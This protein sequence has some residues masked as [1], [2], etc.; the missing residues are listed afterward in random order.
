MLRF[1]L[2]GL[3]FCVSELMAQVEIFNANSK[4]HL[5]SFAKNYRL[6]PK[7]AD[8][9][10]E[11]NPT[12]PLDIL[13][14]N[15]T[16]NGLN[17]YILTSKNQNM[18]LG[19]SE[20]NGFQRITLQ[21]ISDK[22]EEKYIVQKYDASKTTEATKYIQTV[23]DSFL[24]NSGKALQNISVLSKNTTFKNIKMP[25]QTRAMMLEG[26][27]VYMFAFV[28]KDEL[29]DKNGIMLSSAAPSMPVNFER[30]SDFYSS[31]RFHPILKYFAP[32]EGVDLAAKHG[33]PVLCALEGY[34]SEL[35]YSPNIGNYVRIAHQNGF[36][37]VYGH[38]SKTRS[39]L[40]V[41]KSVQRKEIIGLVGQTGL[42][43]GPHLH[44]GVKKDGRYIDPAIFFKKQEYRTYDKEFFAFASTA[45]EKLIKNFNR[46]GDGIEN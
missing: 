16:A 5:Y 25:P 28:F 20:N 37:S 10:L 18:R 38:L 23:T 24:R 1:A 29:F 17:G 12:F 41:G 43:T 2:L 44:F 21:T 27:G 45:R 26:G 32:H 36:E 22:F 19:V 9:I 6:S 13:I 4:E 3:L 34:V 8:K 40:A 42:A 7:L 31:S 14:V 33:T 39:D 30:V 35:S 46:I 11:I 15:K